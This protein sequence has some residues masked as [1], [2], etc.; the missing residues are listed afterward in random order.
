MERELLSLS[1]PHLMEREPLL[2]ILLFLPLPPLFPMQREILL[3]YQF[4]L[5]PLFLPSMAKRMITPLPHLSLQLMERE[6]MMT[7]L[8]PMML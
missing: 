5:L 1:P 8:P 7:P 2:M 4:P 3:L 6:M